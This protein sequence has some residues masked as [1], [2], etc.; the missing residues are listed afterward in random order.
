MGFVISANRRGVTGDNWQSPSSPLSTHAAAKVATLL[1]E[2]GTFSCGKMVELWILCTPTA[3]LQRCLLRS[4]V[5]AVPVQYLATSGPCSWLATGVFQ[6]V[7]RRAVSITL[8]RLWIRTCYISNRHII[9]DRITS[10]MQLLPTCCSLC[11]EL[12]QQK[13]FSDFNTVTVLAERLIVF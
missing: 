10:F 11:V 8:W 4:H 2:S 12:S 7:Q 3:G 9:L 5:D 6:G 13:Q 1:K